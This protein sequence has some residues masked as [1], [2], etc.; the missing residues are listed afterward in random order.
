MDIAIE[1]LYI[2]VIQ[3]K[4]LL[5]IKEKKLFLWNKFENCSRK[6]LSEG[7]KF[8]KIKITEFDEEVGFFQKSFAF[9]G[10]F[11]QAIKTLAAKELKK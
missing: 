11:L 8:F 6:M 9:E 3:E 1:L 7:K 5:R 10:D 2:R 4:F